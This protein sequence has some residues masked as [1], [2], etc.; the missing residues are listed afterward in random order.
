MW[1]KYVPAGMDIP[2]LC[3]WS[4]RSFPAFAL[5]NVTMSIPVCM[6]FRS[7]V[8]TCIINMQE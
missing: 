7:Q 4:F 6:S 2:V 3:G 5:I 8:N 1:Y